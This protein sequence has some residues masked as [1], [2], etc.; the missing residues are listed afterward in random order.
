MRNALE[1]DKTSTFGGRYLAAVDE[2]DVVQS[3]FHSFFQGL[4]RGRF[5]NLRDRN[6]LWALLRVITSL[7]VLELRQRENRQKRGGGESVLDALFGNEPGTAGILQVPGAGPTPEQE[8]AEVEAVARLLALLPKGE[9]RRVA[10]AKLQGLTN[11]EIAA[12]L[13]CP[14]ATVERRLK[15]IR[16]WWKKAAEA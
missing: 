7:K 16:A 14:E 13:A 12:E 10:V 5:P 15:M 6:R 8:A 3:A 9:L 11:K 4:A 1:N 2:E